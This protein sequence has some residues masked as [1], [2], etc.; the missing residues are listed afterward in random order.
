MQRYAANMEPIPEAEYGGLCEN[1]HRPVLYVS[2]DHRQPSTRWA[3]AGWALLV[4]LFLLLLPIVY[5]Y[6]VLIVLW[7][8]EQLLSRAVL[9]VNRILGWNQLDKLAG[10][11]SGQR[12]LGE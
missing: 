10:L 4:L 12:L 3:W 1:C 5:P 7:G 2:G 11:L 6:E 8:A 9:Y